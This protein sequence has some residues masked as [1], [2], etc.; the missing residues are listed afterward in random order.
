MT[1]RTTIRRRL[2]QLLRPMNI[3]IDTLTA[4]RVETARLT[5]AA[6]RGQFDKPL[7]L[8]RGR[9]DSRL[10]EQVASAIASHSEVY[11][12]WE[13][14]SSNSVRFSL[15]NDFFHSPDA[16]V[17]YAMIR[18][19]KPGRII[20]VGSGNSTRVARSA[21]RD[22]ALTCELIAI[23]P[24]PRV[25]IAEIA[26][27]VWRQPV[28]TV[29]PESIASQ[30]Q[31]NDILFI[32]SSHEVKTGGDV[33]FLYLD[34]LPRLNPG[35]IVHIHDIFLPYDYPEDWIFEKGW[36]GN[37]QYVVSA[38]L[39]HNTSIEV[40][41]AGYNLQRTQPHLLRQ[42][43]RGRASSLWLRIGALGGN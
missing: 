8:S 13:D 27:K 22:A 15:N 37:E 43:E 5:A 21:I 20:E 32:D 17:S 38:I 1:A 28:E 35:V 11:K 23:D 41:W 33:P 14:P 12:T 18:L 10:S 25:D 4:D 24:L 6:S 26:D 7:F 9:L 16:E 42:F 40:L 19:L 36:R 39:A 34:L 3:R 31:A 29:P 30:L 2:N